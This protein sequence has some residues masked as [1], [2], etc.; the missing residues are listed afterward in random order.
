[1]VGAIAEIYGHDGEAIASPLIF[2]SPGRNRCRTVVRV[3][4]ASGSRTMSGGLGSAP[5]DRS[6]AAVVSDFA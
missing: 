4:R 6:S 5:S 2:R 1:M 3:Y